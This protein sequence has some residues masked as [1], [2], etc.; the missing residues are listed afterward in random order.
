MDEQ[1]ASNERISRLLIASSADL[2]SLL[3]SLS[4]DKRVD[5]LANLLIGKSSFSDLQES[6]GFAASVLGNHL[7][8]LSETG[9]IKKVRRGIY[10][11]TSEGV[12]FLEHLTDGYLELKI[13]EQQRLEYLKQ[14][15][16]KYNANLHPYMIGENMNNIKT[17][18]HARIVDLPGFSY[19]S[20]HAMGKSPETIA[21]DKLVTWAKPRGLF[22]NPV[23][24]PIYGFNNPNPKKGVPEYGYEFWLV[25]PS[26]FEEDGVEVKHFDGGRYAVTTTQL[27]PLSPDNVIPSWPR[28]VQWSKD[29]GYTCG[30]HQCL[31]K[32]L[33]PF[34]KEEKDILLEL[35]YPIE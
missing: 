32:S 7:Q 8:V 19:V 28:L 25:V 12:C 34:A 9:L 5:I 20:F 29:E 1:C 4:H 6:T 15:I 23:D 22:E 16:G 26:T 24:N 21:F 3:Q 13:R 27:F 2:S 33:N 18:F 35:Y 17:E 31:E 30:T 11:M 10:D 14:I